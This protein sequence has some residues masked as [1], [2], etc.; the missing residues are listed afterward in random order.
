[1]NLIVYT[2]ASRPGNSKEWCIIAGIIIH[3]NKIIGVFKRKLKYGGEAEVLAI[4][5]VLKY[6]IKK[7]PE[8]KSIKLRTD[9]KLF[10]ERFYCKKTSNRTISRYNDML[11]GIVCEFM[12]VKGH[13]KN[14]YNKL[15]DLMTRHK[16][17]QALKIWY[18]DVRFKKAPSDKAYN[19]VPLVFTLNNND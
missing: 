14:P 6:I 2:D 16:K 12:W 9:Y 8:V 18:R 11:D 19:Y 1:M 5:K 7:Y 4:N 17:P 10:I 15:A 13:Y 3:N